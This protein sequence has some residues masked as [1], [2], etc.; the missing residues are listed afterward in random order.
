MN[1]FSFLVLYLIDF[2]LVLERF[3]FLERDHLVFE[4]AIKGTRGRTA[5]HFEEANYWT[6]MG[7][8]N[9]PTSL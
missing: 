2:R 1:R 6:C 4:T 9:I 7:V 5:T 8:H 3:V